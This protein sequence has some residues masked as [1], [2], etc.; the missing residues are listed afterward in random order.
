M[1]RMNYKKLSKLDAQ[2][3]IDNSLGMSKKKFERLWKI[4][5]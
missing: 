2:K 3:I 5:H 4:A 1:K